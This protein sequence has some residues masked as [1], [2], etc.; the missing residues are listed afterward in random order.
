[1]PH[2]L[3]RMQQAEFS[4]HATGEGQRTEPLAITQLLLVYHLLDAAR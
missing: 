4:E 3:F 1:V 2:K